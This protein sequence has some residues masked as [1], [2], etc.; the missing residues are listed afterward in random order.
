MLDVYFASNDHERFEKL[1]LSL[2]GLKETDPAAWNTI[3]D[4]GES[5]CP[6]SPLF[7]SPLIEDTDLNEPETNQ[8]ENGS[9]DLSAIE[10]D[11]PAQKNDTEEPSTDE[12]EFD[13]D[14]IKNEPPLSD[15][16]IPTDA[17]TA[18]L[19]DTDTDNDEETKLSLAQ[20]YIEMEDLV[21][22]KQALD[23]VL[24]SG[25]ENQKRT[26]QQMLDKL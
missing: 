13:F 7:L 16:V 15:D 12:F 8:T 5:I 24:I 1:A 4:M 17:D 2:E 26:A 18:S 25:D 3:A 10:I 21:S 19:K 20:A 11:T 9:N 22:A 6:N 14:L 23:D